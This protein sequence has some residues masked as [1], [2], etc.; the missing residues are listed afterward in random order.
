MYSVLY[1]VHCTFRARHSTL[2][3]AQCAPDTAYIGSTPYASRFRAR[4]MGPIFW[5]PW[6]RARAR[7]REL[8]LGIWGKFEVL[9][10]RHQ[11]LG[12]IPVHSNGPGARGQLLKGAARFS[13]SVLGCVYRAFLLSYGLLGLQGSWMPLLTQCLLWYLE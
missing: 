6:K 7:R 12:L 4:K 5:P 11:G 13:R 3:M 10:G 2:Y 1:I 9:L 8:A